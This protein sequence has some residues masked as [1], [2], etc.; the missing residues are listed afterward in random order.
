MSSSARL[1]GITG[2]FFILSGTVAGLAGASRKFLVDRQVANT[3]LTA[4]W[5][6]FILNGT[7][8]GLVRASREFFLDRQVANMAFTAVC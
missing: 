4:I 5:I 2:Y 7:V 8:A 1:P 6:W 3:A